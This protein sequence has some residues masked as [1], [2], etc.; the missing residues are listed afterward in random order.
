MQLPRLA[1]RAGAQL[2]HH[3]LPA[4][5]PTGGL[6]Q[7]IT[8]HDLAFERLPACFDLAFRR[9]AHLT[10]RA[11]ARGAE[12][13]VCVS[14]TTAA[15]ARELWAVPAQ[16]IVVARHGPGQEL[17]LRGRGVEPPHFLYVG[18]GEPRKNLDVL[19]EAYGRYRESSPAPLELVLAG[20][21][22]ADLTGVRVVVDPDPERLGELLLDA[23]ALVHPSLYEGFGLTPLEAMRLGTPV[24]AA[25]SPGVVEVCADAVRYVPPS[26]AEAWAIAMRELAAEP[27][28]RRQLAGSG[29]RRAAEFSWSESARRHREAYS[30]ALAR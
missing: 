29:R 13:V 24:I 7:V 21:A 5:A 20:A 12:A 15:D 25:R 16:K 23:A 22:R 10:H 27:A 8:V 26:D 11:A 17:P 6:P 2:I 4:R 30:L 14:E 19:L 9:Y 1:R 18:D 28:L 3:P